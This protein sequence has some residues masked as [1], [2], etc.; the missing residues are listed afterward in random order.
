M[1]ISEGDL[2]KLNASVHSVKLPEES[3]GGYMALLEFVHDVHC[4]VNMLYSTILF[5]QVRVR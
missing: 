5:N 3:G 2:K 4:V 1:S